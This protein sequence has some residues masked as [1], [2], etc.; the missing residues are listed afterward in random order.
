MTKEEMITVL[1]LWTRYSE[2]YL[3]GLSREKL[4][5]LYKERVG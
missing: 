2:E 4:E 5:K 3:R 1:L